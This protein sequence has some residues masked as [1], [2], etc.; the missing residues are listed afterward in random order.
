MRTDLVSTL[1]CICLYALKCFP[2]EMV[3]EYPEDIKEKTTLPQPDE[4]QKK[5]AKLYGGAV[6]IALFIILALF[7]ILYYAK[8][9]TTFW[10]VF[11]D[12]K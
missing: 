7:P 3:H 2:W 5:K 1:D 10:Q 4:A 8:T 6:S 9:P 12:R 11:Q